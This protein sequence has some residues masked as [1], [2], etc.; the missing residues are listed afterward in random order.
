MDITV[1]GTGY[2]GLVTGVGLAAIGHRVTCLDIDKEKVKCLQDGEVP[3]YEPGLA[4]LMRERMEQGSLTFTTNVQEAYARGKV[5]F[6]AVGTPSSPDGSANLTYITQV[7]ADIGMYACQDMIVVTKSTVPV[8]T[9]DYI[10]QTIERHLCSDVVISMA[11][12]PEFLR[13]GSGVRDFFQG[14]RIVIGTA[15]EPTASVLEDLFRP[16]AIPIFKTDIRSAEMIKYA[17]NAFL[18][19]KI[20]FI[21]EISNICEKLHA[22]IEDVAAGMGLDQRIG[23]QFLKAGIGYG[24]SCFPKDTDALIQIAGN[25]KHDFQLLKAVIEVNNK[26]QT[27]LVQKMKQLMGLK[28][29]RVAIL[30][31]AFKPNTDDM[32]EAPSLVIADQLLTEGASV[33]AYDPQA[34]EN[35]KLL[36]PYIPYASSIDEAI[37]EADAVFLVTEWDEIKQY[38]LGK[39][40]ELMRQPVIFDGRNCF[41]LERV[42]QYAIDYYSIGRVPVLRRQISV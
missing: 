7:C 40:V 37:S 14:D 16:L 24:G 1:V 33:V 28:G 30:G 42:R 18:A 11:S 29:K 10:K 20:S 13:E 34:K 41:E 19:T 3:I 23:S 9:N 22:D 25:V 21:N 27:L 31:L 32:R 35:A 17:S 5:I 2:V 26:Q 38:P 6:I 8:G 4:E 12:N 36:L 15:D 39:Y